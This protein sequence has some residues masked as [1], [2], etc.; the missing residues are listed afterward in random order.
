MWAFCRSDISQDEYSLVHDHPCL[1]QGRQVQRVNTARRRVNREVCRAVCDDLGL[2]IGYQEIH[3]D[4][5]ELFRQDGVHL[6]DRGLEIFLADIKGGLLLD[7]YLKCSL[8]LAVVGSVAIIG[9][10]ESPH[11]HR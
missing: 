5:P 11:K 9:F 4:R 10:G 3:A 1:E 7:M 2:V 6:S 8:P